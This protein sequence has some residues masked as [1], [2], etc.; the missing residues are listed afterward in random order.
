MQAPSAMVACRLD[1][2]QATNVS[3][4]DQGEFVDSETKD[5]AGR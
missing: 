4:C 2:D 1:R 5:G 3:R